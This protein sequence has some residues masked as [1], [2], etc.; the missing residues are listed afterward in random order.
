M[1]LVKRNSMRFS[2]NQNHSGVMNGISISL[3]S[4]TCIYTSIRMKAMFVADAEGE[5]TQVD[6][7]NLYKDVFTPFQ[8]RFPLLVASDVIKNVNVGF[9]Q[10]QAMVLAGKF[11]VKGVD[12]R[13]EPTVDERFK[14]RWNRTQGSARTF[15]GPGELFYHLE[16]HIEGDGNLAHPCLW[17]SCSQKPLARALLRAH[18]LTHLPSSHS[19]QKPPSQSDTIT[20]PSESHTHPT[21]TPTQ[22]PP[23]PPR[24]MTVTLQKPTTDPPSSSLT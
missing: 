14:C 22:R 5:L 16:D 8:N 2:R 10:A 21:N 6:F 12:R 1:N 4:E 20:L 18:V 23:P 13:K 24:A 17:A 15:S 11:V 9:P 19:P 7:W 3:S